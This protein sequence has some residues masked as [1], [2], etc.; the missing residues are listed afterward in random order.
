[1]ISSFIILGLVI[2][3][4]YKSYKSKKALKELE[5][6]LDYKVKYKDL[7]ESYLNIPKN[8]RFILEKFNNLLVENN[9]LINENKRQEISYR[10]LLANLSHDLRTPLTSIIGY[11]SLIKPEDENSKEYLD[12]VINRSS[13][14][15]EIIEKFYEYSIISNYDI[16]EVNKINLVDFIVS[17]VFDYYDLIKSKNE[18]IDIEKNIE[19]YEIVTSKELLSVAVHNIMDNMVKYSLGENKIL[20]KD[21]GSSIRIEFINKTSLEDGDYSY[22]FEKMRVIDTSRQSS[23]GLG[24]SIVNAAMDKLEYNCSIEVKSKKFIIQFEIKK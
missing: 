9:S 6:F 13:Y 19:F 11:L 3:I 8:Y 21:I 17:I 15:K 5:K 20:I 7:S 22:L 18:S 24:L 23:T 1:M 4:L 2:F 12:I 14:I 16:K 10:E